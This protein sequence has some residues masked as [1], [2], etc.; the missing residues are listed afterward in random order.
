M[1]RVALVHMPFANPRWPSLGLGL[2]KA[3]LARQGIACDVVYLNLDFAEQIGL[4]DYLWLADSF[5]FVLGGERLFAKH[6]FGEGRL[7]D[8]EQYYREILLRSDPELGLDQRAEYEGLG[9]HVPEFLDHALASR[10]WEQYDVVGFTSSFQ[11]TMPSL[12][13]ARRIKQF[14]PDVRIMLGGAACDS[15]MGVELLRLFPLLDYVFLGEADIT[16][17]EVVRQ[18]IAGE[19]MS[20]PPGVAA[21]TAGDCPIFVAAPPGAFSHVGD[22]RA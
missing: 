15:K 22:C 7:P 16:F 19:P 17:P 2:L 20:L 10:D 5:G 3:G 11:Q 4:D 14:R 21:R 8:D 12:C 9:R 13:L 6:F 18:I 1:P